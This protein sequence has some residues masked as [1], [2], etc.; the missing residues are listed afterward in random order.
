MSIEKMLL[1]NIGGRLCD[2]DGALLACFKS[3]CFHMEAASRKMD[4]GSGFK[5]LNEKNPYDKVLKRLCRLAYNIPCTLKGV[6]GGSFETAGLEALTDFVEKSETEFGGLKEKISFLTSEISQKEKALIQLHHLHGLDVDFQKIF[7]C[8][9]VKVRFGK[10][11]ADNQRKLSYYQDKLFF[12]IPFDNEAEYVWGVYFVPESNAT[13]VD[14]IFSSLYFERLRIPDFVQGTAD[15]A[16]D[17]LTNELQK[18]QK[19]LDGY[20]KRM[21]ELTGEKEGALNQAF[22]RLKFLYDTFELR[23]NAS[24]ANDEFYLVGFIPEKKEKS[25]LEFFK[26]LPQVAV[27]CSPP[28]ADEQFTPPV[29]LKNNWFSRPYAMFVEMYGLPSYQGYN[30]TMFVAL[31]YTLLFGVMFGDLGQGIVIAILGA[32]L[33]KWKKMAL[34]PIMTRIG[35]SSA[36]FGLIYGSVFGFEHALD[37]IYP[38]LG[39]AHKPLEVFES[40]NTILVGAVAIGVVLI[41]AVMLLN[42]FIGLK[43]R[44]YEN[45]LFGNSGLAGVIFYSSVLVAGVLAF[46]GGPNLFTPAYI[47]GLIVLPLLLIFFKNPLGN[48]MKGRKPFHESIG[49]FI[50]ENFFELFEYLLSY[51]TNT[52]SFLRVGGFVLSHAGMMLVVMTLAES[53]AGSVNPIV[54]IIGNIFVMG[55]EGMI[56]GIQVLRLEFYEMFSRFYQADG[57]PYKPVK[58]QYTMEIE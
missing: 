50:A 52:L 36:F 45:A 37:P 15:T 13:V 32:V 44:D 19:E 14:N 38:K 11:P 23:K 17:V 33:W 3:E 30:P 9:H 34:G 5:T 58:V 54:V 49:N 7:A 43:N 24:V 1:V 29:K 25:F 41:I 28:D 4:S 16:I 57:H 39:L 53:T 12:F 27:T 47:I 18:Q 35:I 55:M 46:T 48:L 21:K 10:L 2:L 40:T 22:S 6:E 42:V 8:R 26:G 31:T 20:E 56:V 51:I